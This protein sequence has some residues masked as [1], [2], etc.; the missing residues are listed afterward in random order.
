MIQQINAA[1][2]IL[3]ISHVN[4]DGDTLGSMCAMNLAL[5]NL[6]KKTTMLIQGRLPEIYVFLPSVK[7]A[8]S[9][10]ENN[11]KAENFDLVI[12]VD[13][14]SIDRI[15]EEGRKA[16]KNAKTTICFDHHKTNKGFADFNLINPN[17]SSTGEVLYKF[18][19]ENNISITKDIAICLYTA[20]LT[21]TG[22]FK[23][24]ST[25]A[26]TLKIASELV[27]KGVKPNKIYKLCYESKP[28]AMVLF[29]SHCIENA[30]FLEQDKIAY[31]CVTKENLN[32]F[33]AK[34]EYT[35]GICEALRQIN[36]VEI[37]AVLKEVD[38]NTTKISLRS[39]NISVS[40]ITEKFDGGGH[41]FAAG[42]TIHKPLRIAK[43]KLLEEICQKKL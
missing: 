17:A 19:K 12:T 18:F 28:K 25:K 40:D 42:C 31:T 32:K 24:E 37:A 7:T 21:D 23:Y 2:N 33:N 9:Y 5:Q 26:E 35:D 6:G 11:F 41:E 10:R 15:V 13:V 14:A 16:F 43:D 22:G 34:D 3:I 38:D 30:V 39:K 20:V 1:C 8:K 29:Q 27:E 4:P 36:D